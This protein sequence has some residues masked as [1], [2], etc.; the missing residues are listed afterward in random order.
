MHRPAADFAAD[1]DHSAR[2]FYLQAVA[3]DARRLRDRRPRRQQ[4]RYR[5]PGL[6]DRLFELVVFGRIGRAKSIADECSGRR[7]GVERT[8]MRGDVDAGSQARDDRFM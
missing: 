6:D 3:R 4:R 7:S 5:A 8:T 2:V 1:K